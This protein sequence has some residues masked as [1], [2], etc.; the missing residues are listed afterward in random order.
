MDGRGRGLFGGSLEPLGTTAQL[1]RTLGDQSLG[2]RNRFFILTLIFELLNLPGQLGGGIVVCSS[3]YAE[4]EAEAKRQE[5]DDYVS[6]HFRGDHLGS[7]SQI[8]RPESS[9]SD[10]VTLDDLTGNVSIRSSTSAERDPAKPFLIF[11]VIHR[12]MRRATAFH[13]SVPSRI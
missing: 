6:F 12:F 5:H 2:Q 9:R 13:V 4:R 7:K 8:A 11:H 1:W 10:R 3:L